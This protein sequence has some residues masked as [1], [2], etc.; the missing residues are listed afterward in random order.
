VGA[1]ETV[2]LRERGRLAWGAT[3][4]IV[5]PRLGP[6]LAN[7]AIALRRAHHRV[8]VVSVADVP[9]ALAGH[10]GAHGVACDVL[11]PLERRAAV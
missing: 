11:A 8:L 6:G 3:V 9:A 2:F 5:T 7:A 1:P 4:V 10:L